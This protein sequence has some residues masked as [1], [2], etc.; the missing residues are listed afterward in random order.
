MQTAST[1]SPA[2]RKAG[3]LVVA[4]YNLLSGEDELATLARVLSAHTQ[5]QVFP[6]DGSTDIEHHANGLVKEQRWF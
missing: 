2:V 3:E 1:S 4:R 5:V 6:K